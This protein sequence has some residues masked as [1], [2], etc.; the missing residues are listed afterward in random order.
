VISFEFI[1][2]TKPVRIVPMFHMG[3]QSSG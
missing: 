3:F 2:E 1:K